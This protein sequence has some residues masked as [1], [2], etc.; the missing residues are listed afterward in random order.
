[1]T[2]LV[3]V[4][5]DTNT[6]AL[7]L[8]EDALREIGVL[9]EDA[10]A[11]AS[12]ASDALRLMN[13]I[14]EHWANERWLVYTE[15]LLSYPLAGVSPFTIGPSGADMTASRPLKVLSAYATSGDLTYPV[16]VLSASQWDGLPTVPVGSAPGHLYCSASYPSVNVYVDSPTAGYTLSMRVQSLLTAFASTATACSLPPGY[17]D[18]LVL[19]LAKRLAPQYGVKA[20]PETLSALQQV[21][22]DI[23]RINV[24]VP[25]LE[26]M[27][28]V[29]S[30]AW[31]TSG[32]L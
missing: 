11:T 1:M 2:E 14:I 29:S 7:D 18:L 32:G 26:G 24:T 17:D 30:R 8:I 20:S 13:R 16:A 9:S 19:T 22:R 25:V 15:A 5:A 27:Q 23:K 12:Q 28:V 6:T 3:S 31:F 4:V 10:T 21:R